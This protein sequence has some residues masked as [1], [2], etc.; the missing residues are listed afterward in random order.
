MS[1][2]NTYEKTFSARTSIGS[3]AGFLFKGRIGETA[4]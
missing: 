2:A 1:N 3:F 4:D